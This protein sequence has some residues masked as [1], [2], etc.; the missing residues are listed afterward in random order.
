[1]ISRAASLDL[2]FCF[3]IFVVYGQSD[4][5]AGHQ[6]FQTMAILVWLSKNNASSCT[7]NQ[8]R[9][10]SLFMKFTALCTFEPKWLRLHAVDTSKT[11]PRWPAPE[12]GRADYQTWIGRYGG[13]GVGPPPPMYL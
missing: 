8:P 12:C 7:E 9:G 13:W 3:N 2:A 4:P 1:M 5:F 10:K 6:V 11:L